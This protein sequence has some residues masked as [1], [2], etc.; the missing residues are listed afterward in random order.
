MALLMADAR[1]PADTIEVVQI[2]RSRVHGQ[3]VL[4]EWFAAGQRNI[5]QLERF[6]SSRVITL[7]LAH[8]TQ[9]P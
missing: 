6:Q 1:G 5:Q 2:Q 8:F 3:N 7:S 4:S 9:Q